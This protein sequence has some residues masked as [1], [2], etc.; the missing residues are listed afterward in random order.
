[1]CRFL[2]LWSTKWTATPT[3]C[4]TLMSCLQGLGSFSLSG[5][6]GYWQTHLTGCMVTKLQC[7]EAKALLRSSREVRLR[8]FRIDEQQSFVLL[9][10]VCVCFFFSLQPLCKT[11]LA[12]SVHNCIMALMLFT[13]ESK[14][15]SLGSF[16]RRTGLPKTN[17][18]LVE[19]GGEEKS[20][21]CVRIFFY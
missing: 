17:P 11:I 2:A 1:M 8:S 21:R 7:V 15:R 14:R 10:L 20:Y 6:K 4:I 18:V 3:H 9:S 12:A 5:K 13:G 19:T 16:F